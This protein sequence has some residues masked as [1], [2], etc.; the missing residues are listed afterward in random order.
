M[1]PAP[2]HAYA[3]PRVR[4]RARA[5]FACVAAIAALLVVAPRASATTNLSTAGCT[6]PAA[7]S[8]TSPAGGGNA[9]T[10][11]DCGI[12]FGSTDATSM[13]RISQ[14][15]GA[16]AAMFGPGTGSFDGTFGTAGR[17]TLDLTA[18]ADMPTGSVLQRDGTVIVAGVQATGLH[19]FVAKLTAAGILDPSFGTAGVA[20]F[21]L[22]GGTANV[23]SPQVQPD[24]SIVVGGATATSAGIV[25]LLSNGSPDPSFGG[26]DGIASWN[27]GGTL[28]S[29]TLVLRPTGQLLL[30]GTRTGTQDDMFVLQ[31]TPDGVLDTSGFAAPRGWTTVPVGTASNGEQAALSRDGRLVVVGSTCC[32]GSTDPLLVRFTAA[33]Q[34]D[35][36]FSGD[37]IA[38]VNLGTGAASLDAVAF[39]STGSIVA[40]GTDGADVVVL[41]FNADGSGLDPTFGTAGVRT[42][43]ASAGMDVATALTLRADGRILVGGYAN[44][45]TA[46]ADG[47][48]LQLLSNGVDD[49]ALAGDGALELPVDG[50]RGDGVIDLATGP[51]GAVIVTSVHDLGGGDW[52][53]DITKLGSLTISDYGPGSNWLSGSSMFGACLRDVQG[54]DVAASWTVNATCPTTDGSYWNAIPAT[55][56]SAGR[57]ATTS[58]AGVTSAHAAL[59]FGARTSIGTPSATYA[60]PVVVEVVAPTLTPPANTAVPTISGTATA[61]K[62]L[63]ATTGTWTGSATIGYAYQW[64][65]CVP[66]CSNIA[67]ATAAT[68]LVDPLDVGATLRVVVTGTNTEGSATGTSAQTATVAAAPLTSL[69]VLTGFEH[70][71]TSAVGGGI[72][73]SFDYSAG[74]NVFVDTS[75]THSGSAAMRF[76]S[77]GGYRQWNW[78]LGG[79]S[80][81]GTARLY[82]NVAK[83]PASN[84]VISEFEGSGMDYCEVY[85]GPGGQLSAD[86]Y[87]G[88]VTTPVTGPVIEQDRWFLLEFS[89]DFTAG[90]WKLN[91]RVDGVAQPQA[92]FA[93]AGDTM[94]VYQ[95]GIDGP[96][97][98]DVA[99]DDVAASTNKADYPIGPGKVL[100]FR[101]DGIGSVGPF[102]TDNR[103]WNGSSGAAFT[104]GDANQSPGQ[105]SVIDDWPVVTS[106]SHDYL[107]HNN[108][109][110]INV[111]IAD[112]TESVAPTAISVLGAHTAT[113]PTTSVYATL[114]SGGTALSEG[115]GPTSGTVEYYRAT[116]PTAPGG[117][118]WTTAKFNALELQMAGDGADTPRTEALLVEADFPV[119]ELPRVTALPVISGTPRV[120]LTLSTTNGTWSPTP[121]SYAYQWQRCNS[122]GA[123]CVDLATATAQTYVPVAGDQGSRLRV[124]VTGIT[125]AGN[126]TAYSAT[127]III[128]GGTPTLVYETGFEHGTASTAGGGLFD[129]ANTAA[130]TG[131]LVHNGRYSARLATNGI[132]DSYVKRSTTGTVNVVRVAMMLEE[133]PTAVTEVLEV[134][135][136]VDPNCTFE[137]DP[138]T[139][140]FRAALNGTRQQSTMT[141]Q[142]DRWY[143]FDV[144]CDVSA[145]TRTIDWMIDGQP[146]AKVSL[147]LSA[148]TNQ[149]VSVGPEG[150]VT[151][152]AVVRADDWAISQTSA[153]YPLGAGRVEGLTPE[154]TASISTPASFE[155]SSDGASSWTPFGVLD[156]NV[157]PG[158][159][160]L[161]E[162]WPVSYVAGVSGGLVRQ[163]AGAGVDTLDYT[164]RDTG[165]SS[166]PNGVRV[167]GAHGSATP[168]ATQDVTAR[169]RLGAAT[170]TA[171]THD[172]AVA[173]SYAGGMV[174][175]PGGGAWSGADID[176]LNLQLSSSNVGGATSRPWTFALLAEVDYP[177]G[178]M[179]TNVTPP[180][181]SLPYDAPKVGDELTAE[182]G[183]WT[184]AAV[185][186]GH[187]Y[188]WLRCSTAAAGCS[189]ISGATSR[190]YVLQAADVGSFMRVVD[191]AVGD[192][193]AQGARS[194]ATQA[195]STQPTFDYLTGYEH[196]AMSFD[197][198]GIA[199]AFN[200]GLAV[201][202]AVPRSGN[203]SMVAAATGS[204]VEM[205][206]V[207]PTPSAYGVFRGALRLDFLPS[208]TTT[209]VELKTASGRYG[210]LRVTA[211]GLLEVDQYDG[212]AHAVTPGPTIQAGRWYVLDMLLDTS[213][214][215][216]TLDWRLDGAVQTRATYAMGVTD[217]MTNPQWGVDSPQTL[218]ARWD[219]MGFS[220]VR[221]DYPIGDGRVY[222]MRID[223]QA[224][225]GSPALFGLG[226]TSDWV[227]AVNEVPMT[228]AATYVAQSSIV[229]PAA[230]NVP[231]TLQDPPSTGTARAVRGMVAYGATAAGTSNISVRVQRPGDTVA[232]S[233]PIFSGNP[234]AAALSYGAAMVPT[235]AGGWTQAALTATKLLIGFSTDVAPNPR[236]HAAMLEAEYR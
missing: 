86:L 101:P 234:E 49:H 90:Q 235:P 134:D 175:R 35:T 25:R 199:S 23:S 196:G 98:M 34:L 92:A 103:W 68:Y 220:H 60:A 64:Q 18:G 191:L 96:S 47:L 198:G 102:P 30:V 83:F 157:L 137:Y 233:P 149:G 120:G 185:T 201:D 42:Y 77:T 50:S 184:G 171:Y 17:A 206:W 62:L 123:A 65:R 67:G 130:V 230:D 44:V 31:A 159:A 58:T 192:A 9:V 222:G 21:D 129:M 100:G 153:D 109:G 89:C 132:T 121:S 80:A 106:A 40:G 194:A 186:R 108:F 127:T 19:G 57:I 104:A 56:G 26:G 152:P 37:G 43:G 227:A 202:G 231:Y 4:V 229:D 209:I 51:D 46:S 141:V 156:A 16:G 163:V 6:D 204:T 165:V 66:G 117:V 91:W 214:T 200:A 195:V 193:G 172:P 187:Q 218:T 197:G 29:T 219:D 70:Q 150:A 176:S 88:S 5:A 75:V 144:R 188:Q 12:T 14:A 112:T 115:G 39:T 213:S 78:N 155:R 167:V 181:V 95:I 228:S 131:D 33:G 54:L 3:M 128:A 232:A 158:T 151:A 119:G 136:V 79:T 168:G 87:N 216:W 210:R 1:P 94:D 32:T 182:N 189:V 48:V 178:E 53:G 74:G 85:V 183:T 146:Q 126:Q 82:A 36:T 41:R 147:A 55:A 139:G 45:G 97:T 217:S 145:A 99:F 169:A 24:G 179:P 69:K 105:S 170:S 174:A 203:Y 177:V 133:L 72:A 15:D 205:E 8:L 20:T 93:G 148:T 164:L 161:L 166:P 11:Q 223:G 113:G 84:Q 73:S 114:V 111:R 118:A 116:H 107:S 71:T 81:T 135:S 225:G 208:V 122:A 226:G 63:T 207:D 215:T 7:T 224:A 221:S 61:R 190:T 52:R 110:P 38:S 13:L 76:Q 180:S 162:D 10:A 125:S 236:V 27:L 2:A 124:R 142:A 138:A 160:P 211:A 28:V 140:R 22:P 173:Q 212:A 143:V 154:G 59:R